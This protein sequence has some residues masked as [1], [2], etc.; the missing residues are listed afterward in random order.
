MSKTKFSTTSPTY[1]YGNNKGPFKY[2]LENQDFYKSKMVFQAIQVIPPEFSFD[3]RFTAKDLVAQ[4]SNAYNNALDFYSRGDE[5]QKT[6]EAGKAQEKIKAT[7]ASLSPMKF[8]IVEGAK[9]DLYMPLSYTI[10]DRFQYD[11]PSLGALGAGTLGALNSGGSLGGS[12]MRGIEEGFG[13]ITDFFGKAASGDV[14]RV[15]TV[16]ASQA[17]NRV[18]PEAMT[19]AISLAA[20]VTVN[21]NTRAAFRSV[22]LR[23][24]TFQFKFIPKSYEESEEVKKIIKFFRFHAYPDEI[25]IGNLPVGYQY[26]E[27]F[28]IKMMYEKRKTDKDGRFIGGDRQ[29]R[30][31]HGQIKMCYLRSITTN[32][33]PTA[34]IYHRD[35][36][37]VEID[38]NLNFVE[39]RTISRADLPYDDLEY[40]PDLSA[41][42]GGYSEE[43]DDMWT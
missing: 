1:Q 2:P 27:L 36:S 31:I 6:Q 37:P 38:L 29:F 34:A 16:R 33:N 10:N 12:L 28:K 20:Q 8:K 18:L 5:E 13:T 21:P 11:T 42:G 14:A 43:R 9:V 7:R 41:T 35:G 25:T 22:G 23:E 32:Y 30:P 3:T 39:Y 26:P 24:F 15:A 17:M 19:S 4:L 40:D